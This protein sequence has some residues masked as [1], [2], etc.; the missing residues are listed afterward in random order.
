LRFF[1][2]DLG[3]AG[4]ITLFTELCEKTRAEAFE[5]IERIKRGEQVK[6]METKRI[7]KDGRRLDILLT[8]TKLANEDG[9]VTAVAT[10]ERDITE[11]KRM[12]V[13]LKKEIDFLK[14]KIVE[15]K[16]G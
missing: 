15:L 8:A 7:T 13:D 6:N 5:L 4:N 1:D 12:E 16:K 10:T 2:Y 11:Q 14:G 3:Q 9:N